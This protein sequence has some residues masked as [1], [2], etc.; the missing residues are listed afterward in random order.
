[1]RQM[2]FLLLLFPFV[3]F[4]EVI[5]LVP[6][7]H[8]GRFRP[9]KAVSDKQLF[10]T[11]MDE[12][13]LVN[14][15]AAL[16]SENTPRQ[17]I[18][19]L[20]EKV[21][22][23]QERLFQDDFSPKVLPSRYKGEWLPLSTLQL[24][25]YDQ[26]LD[27]LV[28]SPN[29]TLYSDAQFK[30]LRDAYL[31]L[32]KQPENFEN[33]AKLLWASYETIEKRPYLQTAHSVLKYPTRAQL[34][35]EF[36][37]V[38]FPFAELIIGCNLIALFFF[39]LQEL[40]A[41]RWVRYMGLG[42]FS[43]GFILNLIMLLFRIFIL[44]RPPVSN[45][46]ETVVYVPLVASFVASVF[47]LYFKETLI[48]GASTILSVIL[49][50]VLE[51]TYLD[52]SLENVQ[53]VL[54]SQYWLTVHVLMIVASYAVLSLSGVLA[55]FYLILGKEKISK[56]IL[57]TLYIGT[58]LLI[59][60]TLLGGVWAAES[61]GRF[62]DWD[63]KES[64]AFI[65]A[66]VYLIVIHAYRFHKVSGFGLAIGAVIGLMSISFTWYGVNYILGTGLHS[67]GFGTGGEIYY[68]LYLLAECS[69]LATCGARYLIAMAKS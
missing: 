3:L 15:L 6:V 34:Y 30:A 58:A 9:L 10:F 63:P 57:Q 24:H 46:Y 21:F 64:W 23:F 49:L 39:I 22:P 65:S 18:A 42:F 67:Y 60:G 68:Y 33:L 14:Y 11:K 19:Q 66:S 4:A 13:A 44:E 32:E 40:F 62:W 45:M 26:H 28:E 51:F 16:Q 48:L 17:K 59:P 20:V 61:W 12:T 56:W 50:S 5:D 54:N 8:K 25:V 69:F 31:T 53:A 2:I 36:L 52:K 38:Q 41:K 7:A 47:F 55:H 1:M 35:A 43:M 29:F 27:K 37:Y